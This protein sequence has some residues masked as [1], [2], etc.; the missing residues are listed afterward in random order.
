MS[1]FTADLAAFCKDEAPR[2]LTQTVRKIEIEIG[3]RLVMRSP[4]G[5]PDIWQGALF[6]IGTR[7]NIAAP[8]GYVGGRFRANWQYGFSVPPLGELAEVDP[9]GGSTVNRLTMA[10]IA[11]KSFGNVWIVN[12]LPYA[13]S[14]EDGHS[15]QAPF[16]MVSLVELEFPQI[17]EMARL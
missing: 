15:T 12:N 5:D 10:A 8:A 9:S 1:T 11:N 2:A 17:V 13:Q 16:G 7:E 3:N 6:D 14:L 4:V